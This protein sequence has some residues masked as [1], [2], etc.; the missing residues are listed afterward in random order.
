[1]GT[2]Q[3]ATYWRI[4][5]PLCGL[6]ATVRDGELL[7]LRPDPDDPP[8]APEDAAEHG[9]QDGDGAASPRRT[10]RWSCR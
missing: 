8:P 7:R 6:T 1:M 9:L 5:E 3:V 4:G 10:A 2:T